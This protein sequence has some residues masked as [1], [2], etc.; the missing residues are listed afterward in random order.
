MSSACSEVV[1]LR[2][3]L[4]ELGFPQRVATPIHVDNT[5]AIQ[6]D[7]NLVFHERTKHTEVDCHYTCEAYDNNTITLPH[8]TSDLQVAHIFTK[9]L[10]RVKHDFLVRKLMLV[11][12]PTLI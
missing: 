1:W 5:S 7:V 10:P 12:S 11:D 4:N 6:I 3:L 9:A 8:V 2:H